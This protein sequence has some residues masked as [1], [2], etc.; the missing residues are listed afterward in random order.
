MRCAFSLSR[1]LSHGKKKRYAREGLPRTKEAKHLRYSSQPW[2]ASLR[3]KKC[4]KN[5]D[6][7]SSKSGNATSVTPT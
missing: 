6:D 7:T 1:S 5:V 3:D 4:N 2:R